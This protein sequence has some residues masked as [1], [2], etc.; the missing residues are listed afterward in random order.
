MGSSL[1]QAALARAPASAGL[2]LLCAAPQPAEARA[3][4]F[5]VLLLHGIAGGA[6]ECLP[7]RAPSFGWVPP[8]LKHGSALNLLAGQLA[9]KRS[10][11]GFCAAGAAIPGSVVQDLFQE[12]PSMTIC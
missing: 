4:S 9:P 1:P 7:S 3:I 12:D 6:Q 2:L 5:G 8:S 11:C 10:F